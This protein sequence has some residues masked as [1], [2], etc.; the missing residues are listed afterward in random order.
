MG[1]YVGG[2]SSAK[3]TVTEPQGGTLPSHYW[4]ASYGNSYSYDTNASFIGGGTVGYQL[5][6]R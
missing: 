5:A 3:T 1:V 4:K 6:N 2:A